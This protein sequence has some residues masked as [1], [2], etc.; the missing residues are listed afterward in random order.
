MVHSKNMNLEAQVRAGVIGHAIGD[1]LG[2][3]VE[4]SS[5]ESLQKRPIRDMEGF[6]VHNVPAGTWSDDTSMEIALMQSLIDCG[7][8]NYDDIMRNFGKWAYDDEFTAT[9]RT[10]DI[11]GTCSAAISNYLI[12]HK[13]PKNCGETGE[14]SNGNGSL[15]RILPVAYICH[16]QNLSDE[17]TFRLTRDVSAL[18]HAHEISVAGCYI[19][20]NFIRHLL[21]GDDKTEA[22]TKM[23]QHDYSML[24]EE[25]RY[26]YRRLL[27]G[28]IAECKMDEISSSGYVLSSLE[29]ATWCLLT[30]EGYAATVLKA[31]NL[32]KDTDTVGAITGS[33]AGIYYGIE[34]MPLSWLQTLQRCDYL[35]ELC[36]D[37]AKTDIKVEYLR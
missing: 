36:D 2:V 33:M 6:G 9:G 29:A 30:T 25:T 23:Q 22:Y 10:F 15:M 17:D 16:A 18:T 26:A 28:N 27:T 24:S 11:G 35:M 32:G 13:S 1:A 20:V 8:V 14:R 19:Y 34:D 12:G 5:R 31:V 21:D 3:P 4:F 7:Y 37:F